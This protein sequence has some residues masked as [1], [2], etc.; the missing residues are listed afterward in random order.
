M[1]KLTLGKSGISVSRLCFGSLTIGPLQAALSADDGSN[2]IAHALDCGINF[3][4]TAQYYN[5]YEY[6]RLALLKSQRYNTVISTKTY[7]YNRKTAAAAIEEA[8]TAIDRDYIDIFMLHEQESI[9]TLRGHA[10][11]A[12]Y[13]FEMKERGI[14]R[15]TGVSMHHIA[16]V[17]GVCDAFYSYPFDIIHPLFNMTGLGIADGDINGMTL[18]MRR[19]KAMGIGIFAMKAL[20]GGHLFADAGAAFD[21][22]LDAVDDNGL[23]LA[24]SVAVGMQS[25]DEVDA[26]I[27]YFN[28]RSFSPEAEERLRTKRRRLHIENY[29]IGCG[30]CAERC[31]QKAIAVKN[32]FAVCDDRICVLCGYCSAVCPLFA[33]KVL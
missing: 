14:I 20:G 5:N 11:A 25:F 19:A 10:E 12:D 3:I 33:I 18:A 21:F 29:C 30:I 15:A 8:R 22:V 1:E 2:V 26:N 16:A 23:P 4:D 32:G 9:Y 31:G 24:D 13:L 28:K 7:A 6:I 17:N 27:A